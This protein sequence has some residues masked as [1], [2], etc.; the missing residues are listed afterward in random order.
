MAYDPYLSNP[1]F[2]ARYPSMNSVPAYEDGAKQPQ[3]QMS[4]GNP[5]RDMSGGFGYN[6]GYG[7]EQT[8]SIVDTT[9]QYDLTGTAGL[10]G[11]AMPGGG[12]INTAGRVAQ[13]MFGPYGVMGFDGVGLG[14]PQWDQKMAMQRESALMNA[15]YEAR[16]LG[17]G[18]AGVA[19][20]R[21]IT[22]GPSMGRG[23][24]SDPT[25]G[26]SAASRGGGAGERGRDTRD[27]EGKSSADRHSAGNY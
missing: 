3:R 20:G 17:G 27:R 4:N 23:G 2:R 22:S 9:G 6:E 18:V 24:I 26:R 25:L 10:I 14:H 12:F 11:L 19:S 13:S 15:A 5:Y 1:Y 7:P 8:G 16:N 21:S